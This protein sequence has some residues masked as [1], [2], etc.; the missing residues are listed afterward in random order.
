MSLATSYGLLRRARA[1]H[2]AVGAFNANNMEM[3]QAVVAAAQ[4]ERAPVILQI[5]QGAIRYAGLRYA[6]GLVEIAASEV[7]VPVVLHLDHG[8]DF[9]QNVRCL[10]EGFTSLM[11]DGSAL[12]YEE[13][14]AQ[15]RRIVEMAH[16]AGVPVEGELGRVPQSGERYTPEGAAALLT[17]PGQAADFVE[18]TGV[19]SLAVAIGSIHGMKLQAAELD[20]ERLRAIAERVSVPLVLHGASGVHDKSL[21]RA[22]ELGIAKVNVATH[23]NQAFSLAL[24]QTVAQYPEEIEA[25][26][27]LAPAREAV[28]EAV[29][30]KLRLFRA[31]GKAEAVPAA[32][33]ES[34]P[35]PGVQ[36]AKAHEE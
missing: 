8:S 10:R 26:R 30:A 22:I 24:R 2:Y 4:E 9:V 28:K 31:S 25:R 19:D 21:V 13:N 20:L 5:S 16:S 1:E 35:G 6:A 3:V 23:L 32:L 11:F 12:P 15:T 14:I 27:L 18:R 33:E 34:P 7:R 36:R 17:D 29:R